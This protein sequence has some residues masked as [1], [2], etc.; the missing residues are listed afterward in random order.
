M[1]KRN[2]ALKYGNYQVKFGSNFK[3]FCRARMMVS[4]IGGGGLVNVKQK[5]A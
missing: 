2:C 4:H 3:G 5:Q 1:L